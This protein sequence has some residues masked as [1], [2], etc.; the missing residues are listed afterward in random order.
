M[1]NCS[2]GQRSEKLAKHFLSE[3]IQIED[4]TQMPTESARPPLPDLYA[5]PVE[6]LQLQERPGVGGATGQKEKE[7][8]QLSMV[9]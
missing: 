4:L 8:G 3:D 6:A 5:T 9:M 2:K 7:C 1:Q